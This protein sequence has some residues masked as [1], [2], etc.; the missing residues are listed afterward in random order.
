MTNFCMYFKQI[1]HGTPGWATC[2]FKMFLFCFCFL[3]FGTEVP[4]DDI[5]RGKFAPPPTPGYTTGLNEV[6]TLGTYGYFQAFP[7]VL[8]KKNASLFQNVFMCALTN[9]LHIVNFTEK[10]S[11][12]LDYISESFLRK[13][14]SWIVGIL[15]FPVYMILVQLNELVWVFNLRVVTKTVYFFCLKIWECNKIVTSTTVA[16]KILKYCYCNDRNI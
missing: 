13:G 16:R 8:G 4:M 15:P 9:H 3:F 7:V 1:W 6:W 5:K 11:T 10:K 12:F 2:P 14:I